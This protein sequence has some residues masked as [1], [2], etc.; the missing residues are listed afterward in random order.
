MHEV[1]IAHSIIEII[2]DAIPPATAGYVSSVQIKVGALSAI[3]TDAL[4]FAFDIVK[5]KTALS[6]ASLLIDHV[7]GKGQCSDCDTIFPMHN[8]ATPCPKCNSYLVKILEGKEMKVLS[9][10]MEDQKE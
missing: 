1:S 5:A 9:F 4:L 7:E 8:Y 6:K 2:Q 3:E 10:D